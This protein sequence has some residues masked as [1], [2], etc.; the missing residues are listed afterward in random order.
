MSMQHHNSLRDDL[1]ESFAEGYD[2]DRRRG[3]VFWQEKERRKIGF[4]PV[5]F[6]VGSAFIVSGFFD[7]WNRALRGAL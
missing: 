7:A 6:V 5:P 1:A 4:I 3:R 2:V